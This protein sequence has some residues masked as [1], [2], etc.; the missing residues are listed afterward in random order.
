MP[1]VARKEILGL[2]T[3]ACFLSMTMTP[4]DALTPYIVAAAA[5]LRTVTDLISLGS[6]ISS[7]SSVGYPST[8]I[9]G[10]W[11]A[12]MVEMPRILNKGADVGVPP[13]LLL[14]KDT[15]LLIIS[16]GSLLTSPSR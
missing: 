11:L 12:D 9:S 7:V 16:P 15:L 13:R 6:I 4:L 1:D 5:S 2:P 10:L 8:T 14:V 3:A